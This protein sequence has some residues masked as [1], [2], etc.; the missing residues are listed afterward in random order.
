MHGRFAST[1]VSNP[2]SNHS[3]V[4]FLSTLNVI[5]D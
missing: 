5:I 4:Y 2:V 1:V 3:P